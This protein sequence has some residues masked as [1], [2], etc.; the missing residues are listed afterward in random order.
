MNS[1]E[2][3][4]AIQKH[5]G[6]ADKQIRSGE[7][8]DVSVFKNETKKLDQQDRWSIEQHKKKQKTLE[9]PFRAKKLG[10]VVTLKTKGLFKGKITLLVVLLGIGRREN[11]KKNWH[12]SS[13]TIGK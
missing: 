7:K 12:R 6:K 10:D 2:Q 5:T 8:G 11:P 3:V 9:S 13:F 4:R 1:M